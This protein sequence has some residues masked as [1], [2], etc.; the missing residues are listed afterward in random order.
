MVDLDFREEHERQDDGKER[1]KLAKIDQIVKEE[2]FITKP[3][4]ADQLSLKEINW[5]RDNV[6][7]V[8]ACGGLRVEVFWTRSSEVKVKSGS[9][10][11]CLSSVQSFNLFSASTA[12][13]TSHFESV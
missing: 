8:G 4:A 3:G 5:K 9:F 11:I 2:A 1:G 12:P 13:E 6:S 7:T 10:V